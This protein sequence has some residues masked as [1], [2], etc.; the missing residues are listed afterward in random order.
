VDITQKIKEH[1]VNGELPRGEPLRQA[2]LSAL[3][4]VSRLEMHFCHN[5]PKVGLPLTVKRV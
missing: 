5:E 2:E 4:G 3:Y 1:I